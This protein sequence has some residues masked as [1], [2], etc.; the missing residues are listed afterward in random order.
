MAGD[1]R[2]NLY[3]I[4]FAGNVGFAVGGMNDNSGNYYEIILNTSDGGTTWVNQFSGSSQ[5]LHS[6]QTLDG[7]IAYAV[8]EGG[9]ILKTTN[10]GTTWEQLP[11]PTNDNFC[12][13]FFRNP[14]VGYVIG[15]TGQAGEG[16]IC[17]LTIDG[18]MTWS[19]QT[20][21]CSGLSQVYITDDNKGFCAGSNGT[22]L[23]TGEFPVG[24]NSKFHASKSE[25]HLYPNPAS[26]ELYLE[27]A[28]D[29]KNIVSQI[30]VFSL[31]GK[32]V[33]KKPVSSS[34]DIINI[35]SLPD[36]LYFIRLTN[37]EGVLNGK[38]V[39]K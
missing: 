27:I 29:N 39:K 21:F 2:K 1:V 7:N 14:N 19:L 11:A 5:W 36:G 24:I 32:E 34:K 18:G 10:G 6:V 16:A 9:I 22:I 33:L 37:S 28:S 38:F 31:E 12:S 35:S 4:S 20:S 30:T 17:L 23:G 15:N 8:G 26:S 25:M 3:G 13:V